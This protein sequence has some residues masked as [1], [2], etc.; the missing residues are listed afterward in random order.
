MPEERLAGFISKLLVFLEAAV[1][2][3]ISELDLKVETFPPAKLAVADVFSVV[4]PRVE[5]YF[6][7]GL[8]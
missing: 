8:V 3:L 7:P 1:V 4:F 6:T 2:D 5:V